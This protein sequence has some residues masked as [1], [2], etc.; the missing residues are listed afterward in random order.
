MHQTHDCYIPISQKKSIHCEENGDMAIIT[1]NNIF[2]FC[3]TY[4]WQKR[5]NALAVFS[6]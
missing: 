1:H 2:E 5:F 4:D 3:R 6:I